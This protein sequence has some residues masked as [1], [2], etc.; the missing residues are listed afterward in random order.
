MDLRQLINPF[1]HRR[2]ELGTSQHIGKGKI[3]DNEGTE[4]EANLG[5][6]HGDQDL[7][8]RQEQMETEERAG[9]KDNGGQDINMQIQKV[10][11]NNMHKEKQIYPETLIPEKLMFEKSCTDKSLHKRKQK[12]TPSVSGVDHLMKESF[13]VYCCELVCFHN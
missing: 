13:T 11:K 5:G 12:N 9:T 3:R 8:N 7:K 6:K 1:H 4:T 10:E 2:S